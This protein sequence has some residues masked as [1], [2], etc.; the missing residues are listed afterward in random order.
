[1][2]SLRRCRTANQRRRVKASRETEKV[3]QDVLFRDDFAC[4]YCG[5]RKGP[6]RMDHRTPVSRGGSS[7]KANLATACEDCDKAKGDMTEA[8]FRASPRFRGRE[9]ACP[10]R[11]GDGT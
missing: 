5:S 9:R 1:M 8:E 4:V 3:R 10:A 11:M 6:L 7:L 2:P